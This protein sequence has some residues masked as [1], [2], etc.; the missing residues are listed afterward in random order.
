MTY[1]PIM[2]ATQVGAPSTRQWR[3]ITDVGAAALECS[4]C[5]RTVASYWRWCPDC[6]GHLREGAVIDLRAADQVDDGF[7]VDWAATIEEPEQ[8]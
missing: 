8:A 3:A 4:A 6:G 1:D 7:V 5:G 2:T